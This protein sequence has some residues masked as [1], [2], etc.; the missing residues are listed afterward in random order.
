MSAVQ[1]TLSLKVALYCAPF[2]VCPSGHLEH[3][4]NYDVD[5]VGIVDC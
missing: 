1:I 5:V 3:D 4:G 2:C